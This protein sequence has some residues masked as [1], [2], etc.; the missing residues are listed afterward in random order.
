MRDRPYRR[1]FFGFGVGVD[2]DGKGISA[3]DN[4]DIPKG[5]DALDFPS[6]R[7]VLGATAVKGVVAL[8]LDDLGTESG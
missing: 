3:E 1:R 5:E 7:S 2:K 4:C 8:D 6:L